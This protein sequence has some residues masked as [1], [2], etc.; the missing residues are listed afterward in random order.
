VCVCRGGS[1]LFLPAGTVKFNGEVSNVGE[2]HRIARGLLSVHL[3]LPSTPLH[4]QNSQD[5]GGEKG[6]GGA[7]GPGRGGL[8]RSG[9]EQGE[10]GPGRGGNG[11][12]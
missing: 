12:R 7:G 8:S 10:D 5:C 11:E 3:L 2:K 1:E 9:E 6:A 4:L